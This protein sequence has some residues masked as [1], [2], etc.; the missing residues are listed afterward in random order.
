MPKPRLTKF[1]LQ[2]MDALWT[3]GAFETD[4][5]ACRTQSSRARE[6][7][8]DPHDAAYR[9]FLGCMSASGWRRGGAP[10]GAAGA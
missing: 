6:G 4:V 7:A 2:I 5:A 9:A 3:R 1:E 10:A 8:A